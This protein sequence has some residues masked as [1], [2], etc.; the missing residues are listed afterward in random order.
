MNRGLTD[1]EIQSFFN[2]F[3]LKQIKEAVKFEESG[4]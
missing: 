1:N 3:T 2:L 4:A